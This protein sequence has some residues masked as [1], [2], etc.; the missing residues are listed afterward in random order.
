MDLGLLILRFVVGLTLAAHGAQKLSD[1]LAATV[2]TARANSWSSSASILVVAMRR[3]R[4]SP[5]RAAAC[6][7]RWACSRRSAQPWWRP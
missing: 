1:G 3:W 6:C 7:S 4:V 2:S 5:R